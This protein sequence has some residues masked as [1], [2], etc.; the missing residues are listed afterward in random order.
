MAREFPDHGNR[1]TTPARRQTWI[2]WVVLVLVA[3][4]VLGLWMGLG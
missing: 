1:S 2:R 3:S 4:F